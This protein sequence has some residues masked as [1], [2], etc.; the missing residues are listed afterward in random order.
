QLKKDFWCG[1][2]K[3]HIRAYRDFSDPKNKELFINPELFYL[4]SLINILENINK[5]ALVTVSLLEDAFPLAYSDNP[6][7]N[8]RKIKENLSAL[9][10]RQLVFAHGAINKNDITNAKLNDRILIEINNEY[11]NSNSQRGYIQL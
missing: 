9:W 11:I 4:Y 6:N 5:T 1:W 10:E 7:Y 8:R 3:A 2:K